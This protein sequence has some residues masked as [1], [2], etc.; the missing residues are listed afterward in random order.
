[1]CFSPEGIIL[2]SADGDSIIK[3]W[4]WKTGKE[5]KNLE[6]HTSSI[7]SICFLND[8]KMLASGGYK[9]IKLWNIISGKVIRNLT[10]HTATVRSICLSNDG[11]TLVSGSAD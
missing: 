4:N 6:G 10:E 8:G 7:W 1:M 9:I 3:L 11:K 5:I 2:A